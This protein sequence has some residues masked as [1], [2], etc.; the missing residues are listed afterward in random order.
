MHSILILLV[1][2]CKFVDYIIPDRK[3][4]TRCSENRPLSAFFCKILNFFSLDPLFVISRLWIFRQKRGRIGPLVALWN[5][6][7]VDIP[8]ENREGSGYVNGCLRLA[9]DFDLAVRR[10]R[11]IEVD[12]KFSRIAC[13]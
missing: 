4:K 12:L 11:G 13:A 1:C 2:I 5:S 10:N 7:F 9:D 3:A 6:L 8:I